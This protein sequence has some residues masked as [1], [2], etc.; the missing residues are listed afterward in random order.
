[1]PPQEKDRA[2]VLSTTRNDSSEDILIAVAA[3][4]KIAEAKATTRANTET[5]ISS[6]H[7]FTPLRVLRASATAGATAAV[8]NY[9]NLFESHYWFAVFAVSM[10]VEIEPALNFFVQYVFPI[11]SAVQLYT[12][13]DT[14]TQTQLIV[15]LP[16]VLFLIGVP[17]S[18]CLHRYFSH[19]AFET[20]RPLQAALG[21]V[22]TFAY[23]GG[24]LWWAAKHTRHHHHCDQPADPHSVVQQGFF[25]AF[26][27]WTMNPANLS[28]RDFKYNSANLFVPEIEF[29]D[30]F[31]LAPP[32]LVFT[33]IEA[34][35]GRSIVVYSL[36][37]PM[38]FCRLI[39]LLFNVEYHPIEDPKRCKSVDNPRLLAL[40]VGESEHDIHHKKPRLSK[41]NDWD[42]PCKYQPDPTFC[43]GFSSCFPNTLSL[44]V[45]LSLYL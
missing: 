32:C 19:T 39:T 40:I 4:K 15:F 25:Y 22:A 27:G 29:L 28:N 8:L 9:A 23:Q 3:A 33:A 21:V 38:L 13:G 20:S 37:L 11:W 5:T 34:Y 14:P 45:I 42:L 24:P 7:A 2:T 17:M 31:Y 41:R 6:F 26:C 36:L 43:C 35:F 30:R 18:V 16:T 1:M 12:A 10:A 44:W